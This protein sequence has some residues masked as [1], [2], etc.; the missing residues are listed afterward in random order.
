MEAM[1]KYERKWSRQA[2]IIDQKIVSSGEWANI[3][4]KTGRS[5]WEVGRIALE[6]A[7]R[8]DNKEKSDCQKS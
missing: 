4:I 6:W 2:T 8:F 3:E 7:I 1:S 5:E